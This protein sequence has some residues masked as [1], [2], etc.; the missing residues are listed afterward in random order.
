MSQVEDV[1]IWIYATLYLRVW[2][3]LTIG[4]LRLLVWELIISKKHDWYTWHFCFWLCHEY[5]KALIF[6]FDVPYLFEYSKSSLKPF[7]YRNVTMFYWQQ[8]SAHGVKYLC[9][10]FSF[11]NGVFRPQTSILTE[12]KHNCS[13]PTNVFPIYVHLQ[14]IETKRR[15]LVSAKGPSLVLTMAC[16]RLG[17]IWIRGGLL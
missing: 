1:F 12:N 14:P 11:E 10:I 5:C 7:C 2:G 4:I 9:K 6:L 15:I 17:S 16:R 13:S 3:I 8:Q